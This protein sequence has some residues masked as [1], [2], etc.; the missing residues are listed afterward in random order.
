MKF[1]GVVNLIIESIFNF[2]LSLF[3]KL[4]S[5]I[6]LPDFPPDVEYY[7]EE[8]FELMQEGIYILNNVMDMPYFLTLVFI[9]ISIDI[10]IRLYNFIMWVLNKIP[11]LDID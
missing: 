3:S 1:S 8:A 11:A 2:F 5:G 7:L 9:S 10:G 6:D 4:T